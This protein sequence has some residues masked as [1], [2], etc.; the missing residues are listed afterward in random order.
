MIF[1]FEGLF[2]LLVNFI[3]CFGISDMV[4]IFMLFVLIMG[5]KMLRFLLWILV[6][7]VF[8]IGILV[9]KMLLLEYVFCFFW[10]KMFFGVWFKGLG[11]FWL[12]S[13]LIVYFIWLIFFCL[14]GI[15]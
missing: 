12:D 2:F 5:V 14:W 1:G 7:E 3:C 9:V 6:N 15:L 8:E 13:V 10:I 4:D 11:S